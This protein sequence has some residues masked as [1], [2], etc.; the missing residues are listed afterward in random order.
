MLGYGVNTFFGTTMDPTIKRLF[1]Q[2]GRATDFNTVCVALD[3]MSTPM[4]CGQLVGIVDASQDTT[5]DHNKNRKLAARC[6]V[7]Y[8]ILPGQ[9]TFFYDTRPGVQAAYFDTQHRLL[10]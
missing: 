4:E 1:W 9:H 5:A 7:E 6:G 2:E 10:H 8:V 3:M